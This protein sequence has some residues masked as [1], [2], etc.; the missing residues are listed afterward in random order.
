MLSKTFVRCPTQSLPEPGVALQ[1]VERRPKLLRGREELSAPAAIHDLRKRPQ[2]TCN[3]RGALA[4]GLDQ[5]D[6]E[7]LEAD[8]RDDRRQRVPVIRGQLF[9]GHTPEEVDPRRV[10]GEPGERRAVSAITS[11]EQVCAAVAAEQWNDIVQPFDAL[12]ATDE[13]KVRPGMGSYRTLSSR[14]GR[15]VWQKVR[16]HVHGSG[17]AQLAVLV[18]AELAHRDERIYVRD[19]TLEIARVPPE[20][21][22]SPVAQHAPQALLAGAQLAAV[23]PQDLRGAHEPLLVCPVEL[24][25]VCA[26]RRQDARPANQRHVVVIDYVE[27]AGGEQPPDGPPGADR[28]TRLLR[29]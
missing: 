13:Q 17:K 6:T 8:R 4:E 22:R 23:T 19:L 29:Q 26:S 16:K 24:E 20:L 27:P 21:R 25:G 1:L 28:R 5:D 10:P 7:R 3:Y 14:I 15:R 9:E 11:D 2:A 12:K 18:P